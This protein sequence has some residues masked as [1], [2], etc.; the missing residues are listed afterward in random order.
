MNRIIRLLGSVDAREALLVV[1]LALLAFEIQPLAAQQMTRIAVIDMGRI[2]DTFSNSASAVNSF[3]QKKAEI[4]TEVDKR[5][6]EIKALQA[7]KAEAQSRS[8]TELAQSIDAE[9]TKR[10]AELKEYVAA[11]QNELDIMAKAISASGSFLQ[12]IDSCVS[13]VAESEGY[14]IVLN[15]TPKDDNNI[16]V[17]NSTAIDITDEVILALRQGQ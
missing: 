8:D 12:K 9:I 6:G 10:T 3:A 16:I 1:V 4:Q 14:S 11:R 13:Q 2:L 7:K 5:A 17:W 15:L